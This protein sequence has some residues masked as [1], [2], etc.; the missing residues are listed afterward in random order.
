MERKSTSSCLGNSSNTGL[1]HSFALPGEVR[2]MLSMNKYIISVRILKTLGNEN[3]SRKTM[4][5]KGLVERILLQKP[6]FIFLF[7]AISSYCKIIYSSQVHM[8]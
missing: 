1:S 6:R 4:Y 5:P 7:K 2:R 3:D 8:Y